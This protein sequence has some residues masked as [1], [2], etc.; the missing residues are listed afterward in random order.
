MDTHLLEADQY[1]IESTLKMTVIFAAS[2]ADAISKVLGT[3]DNLKG[4]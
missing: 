1:T 4:P 3:P 2:P